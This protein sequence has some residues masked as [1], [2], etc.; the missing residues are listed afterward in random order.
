MPLNV[1]YE[2]PVGFALFQVLDEGKV[3]D[4]SNVENLFSDPSQ[5]S[6][7][8]ELKKFKK[9][10]DQVEAT[11]AAVSLTEG[12]IYMYRFFIW[13]WLNRK[14]CQ[15]SEKDVEKTGKRGRTG[16]F[17]GGRYKVRGYHPRKSRN[18]VHSFTRNSRI[19]PRNSGTPKWADWNS[20]V[21]KVRIVQ[22]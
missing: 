18:W 21:R 9:F 5:L 7:V 16:H 20:R 2:S 17:G 6:G 14:N 10:T 22:I 11:Q 1:L 19:N 15:I 3:K 13:K 8:L 12:L 4:V